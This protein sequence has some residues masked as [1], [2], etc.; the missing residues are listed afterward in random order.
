M[1]TAQALAAVERREITA[2][3]GARLMLESDE[4]AR[5]ALWPRWVP[6]WFR[7]W[8]RAVLSP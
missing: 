8:V 7:R 1:T 5:D 4:R 2:A 6:R 3:E